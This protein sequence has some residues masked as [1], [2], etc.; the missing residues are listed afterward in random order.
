M[1]RHTRPRT[2]FSFFKFTS[3]QWTSVKPS[4]VVARPFCS[5]Q[6]NTKHLSIIFCSLSSF[7][8]FFFCLF[9]FCFVFFNVLRKASDRSAR[10]S[11][12]ISLFL[13][14]TTTYVHY[15]S[16]L[17]LVSKHFLNAINIVAVIFLQFVITIV[18]WLLLLLLPLF[19]YYYCY[20]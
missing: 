9:F 7:L 20:H 12:K 18:R 8:S 15:E 13:L 11:P 1:E 19:Y 3:V 4:L 14:H 6:T 16:Q 5:A 2:S 17:L 10:C